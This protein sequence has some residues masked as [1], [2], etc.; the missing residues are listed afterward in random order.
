MKLIFTKYV[1]ATERKPSRIKASLSAAKGEQLKTVTV[2]YRGD[3][4]KEAHWHAARE[5]M[6][7]GSYVEREPI[8]ETQTEDGY[9]FRHSCNPCP[10]VPLIH[11]STWSEADHANALKMA[12]ELGYGN[13][14]R[15][16]TWDDVN[17]SWGTTSDLHGYFCLP[18]NGSMRQGAII[19]TQDFGLLFVQDFEDITGN[20]EPA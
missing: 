15:A 11:G 16:K 2:S 14:R 18:H 8:G 19:K 1:P 13:H 20:V 4:P 17:A 3:S 6:Q 10:P 7:S 5:L 9:I 12:L